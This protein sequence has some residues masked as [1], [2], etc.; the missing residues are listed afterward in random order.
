[1]RLKRLDIDSVPVSD[2]TAAKA[3]YTDVLGF[4]VMRDNVTDPKHR[5][6]QL[7][8]RGAATSIR[9]VDYFETM[10]PGSMQ[11]SVLNTDDLY[12]MRQLLAGRGLEVSDVQSAPWGRFA[13]FRDPD[14][15]GWVLVQS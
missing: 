10:P 4:E 3:F 2:P 9:L 7:G 8:I 1:M 11:G 15:N 12:G 14:G 6:I 5:W 13:I